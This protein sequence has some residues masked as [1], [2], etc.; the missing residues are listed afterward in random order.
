[1]I[2]SLILVTRIFNSLQ[3]NFSIFSVINVNES[4]LFKVLFLAVFNAVSISRLV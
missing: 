2:N 1:M 4:I 3:D